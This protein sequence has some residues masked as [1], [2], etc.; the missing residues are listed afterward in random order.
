RR[1]FPL[2]PNTFLYVAVVG[3]SARSGVGPLHH[4]CP[5][6]NV[7]YESCL[8]LLFFGSDGG[9]RFALFTLFLRRSKPPCTF[10]TSLDVVLVFAVV[11]KGP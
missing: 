8:G 4:P 1:P 3:G 10:P 11:F 6:C 5:V 9:C 2:H 7:E